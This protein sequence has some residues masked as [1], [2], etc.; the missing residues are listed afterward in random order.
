ML[1]QFLK[2][3][4]QHLAPDGQ[5]WLIISDL[6]ELIGLRDP[7][8]LASWFA[9]NELT[10]QDSFSAGPTHKK[11][12]DASDPLHA[13]RVREQTTLYVLKVRPPSCPPLAGE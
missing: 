12:K 3:A 10:C 4:G 7:S 2:E 8:Q 5:I 13:C 9:E 11:I 6:A 1:W